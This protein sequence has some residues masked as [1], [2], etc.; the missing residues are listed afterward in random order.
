M[1]TLARGD[2]TV[3]PAFRSCL[4][5]CQEAKNYNLSSI[6]R[7]RSERPMMACRPPARPPQLISS[8]GGEETIWRAR[9]GNGHARIPRVG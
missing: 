4:V 9:G 1:K 2:C 8:G 5:Y 3:R 6:D 7:T